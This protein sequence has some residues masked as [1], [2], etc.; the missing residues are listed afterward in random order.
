MIIEMALHVNLATKMKWVMVGGRR[1]TREG[2]EREKRKVL[3]FW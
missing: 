1:G 3:I 2:G